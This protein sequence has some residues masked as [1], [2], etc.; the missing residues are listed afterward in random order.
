MI[1]TAGTISRPFRR[2][3]SS[4][5]YVMVLTFV[6]IPIAMC[7]PLLMKMITLYASR[8]VWVLRLPFG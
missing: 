4:I 3:A 5:E 8:V 2:G 1:R 7:T 6:V